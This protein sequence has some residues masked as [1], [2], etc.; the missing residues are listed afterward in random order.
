[1]LI[2]LLGA[3]AGALMLSSAVK[4]TAEKRAGDAQN[5]SSGKPKDKKSQN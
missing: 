5:P 1:M 4:T 3:I 2:E